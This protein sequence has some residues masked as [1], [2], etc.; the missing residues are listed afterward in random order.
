MSTLCK[1]AI[2]DWGNTSYAEAFNRQI[3]L[4][5]QRLAGVVPDTLVFTEHNPVYTIGKRKDAAQNLL[6]NNEQ[7]AK[8]GI[9]VFQTNRGG[10]IT[11]HGP[12]QCVGYPII[13]LNSKRDLHR[14]LRDLEEV[15]IRTLKRFGLNA[16][17]REGKTGIWIEDRKIAAIG[18]AVKRWV[19]YH[20]FALNVNNDLTPFSGIIPCGIPI[21]EGKVT[22]LKQETSQ[23]HDMEAVKTLLE[24]E[25]AK[26]FV[27]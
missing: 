1:L 2:V 5:E 27:D 23:A 16:T 12:G 6:L 20:G 21:T 24:S 22:S 11:Y 25:F 8:Q 19:T 7:L 9:E 10:D 13:D 15:I 4:V 3:Q 18:V 14:Y 26:T 17:R